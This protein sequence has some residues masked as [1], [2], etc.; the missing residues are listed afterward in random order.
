MLEDDAD[1]RLSPIIIIYDGKCPFC[2]SYVRFLRLQDAVGSV[3][4][5]DARSQHPLAVEAARS[6]D[7]D[8]GMVVKLRGATYHGADA[9]VVLSRLSSRTRFLNRLNALLFSYRP[10]AK[11]AYPILRAGRRLSLYWKQIPAIRS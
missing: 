1:L 8:R 11:L 6:L 3:Q 4:L 2:D 9:M 10:F 5:V 7:V